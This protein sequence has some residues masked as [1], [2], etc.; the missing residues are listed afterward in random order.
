MNNYRI[1]YTIDSFL[2]PHARFYRTSNANQAR[3]QF[4]G[5]MTE[6]FKDSKIHI[7][8]IDRVLEKDNN[9]ITISDETDTSS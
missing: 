3:V 6:M 2:H 4:A 1:K 5:H 7:V 8:S 9:I